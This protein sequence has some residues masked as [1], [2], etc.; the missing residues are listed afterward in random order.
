[1]TTE[2][3]IIGTIHIDKD[4]SPKYAEFLNH[5]LDTIKPDLILAEIANNVRDNNVPTDAKPEY[6]GVI[7]PYARA[8]GLEIKGV[9]P[10][11]DQSDRIEQ[12]KAAIKTRIESNKETSVIWEFAGRWEDASYGRILGMLD[13]PVSTERLQMREY[14]TLNVS[15]W[16]ESLSSYFPEYLELWNQWNTLILNN[17]LDVI[18]NHTG[19]R[20]LLTIGLAHKYWLY[21]KLS[22]QSDLTVYDL[23]SFKTRGA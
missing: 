6:P 22:G 4:T 1:M 5:A 7:F 17:I 21:E 20:L 12:A 18:K 9:L 23:P 19:Q 15:A 13:N 2:L 16:F 8:N 14:D 3:V 11:Q 10:D